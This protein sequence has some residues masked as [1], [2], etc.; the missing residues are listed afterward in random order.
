MPPTFDEIKAL[1]EPS[2]GNK[3]FMYLD[4]KGFV[5]V[6]IGNLIPTAD[7]AC[8]LAFV[9]R[10]TQAAASAGEIKADFASVS[11]QPKAKAANFYRQFTKL[12][13]PEADVDHL[14]Q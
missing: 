5:T 8:A 12:D 7:A 10:A 14:F 1:L 6:G 9:N 3:S 2:E 4:T 11:A 13:L